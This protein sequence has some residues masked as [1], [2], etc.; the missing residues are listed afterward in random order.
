LPGSSGQSS[1]S[2]SGHQYWQSVA[3]IGIQVAEALAYAHA[4]G[5]LHRDIKPSNLLLDTRGTVWITDFGLAKEA[6]SGDLTH[7]GDLVGTLRYMAPERF[8]GKSDPRSDLYGLGL[9]LYELLTLRPAHDVADRNKLI[10]LVQHEEPPRPRKL[11]PEVPRDLETIVLKAIA[12]EPEHRYATAAALAE[13]L[14]R[15]VEDKPIQARRVG[16]V[17][18]LWRWCR[19]NR[20]IASLLAAVALLLIAVTAVA[21]TFAAY[22]SKAN[23]DLS[24][25]LD[26]AERN[27]REAE[28]RAAS[29]AVDLDLK[30]CEDRAVEY[31]VLRLAR[32]LGTLPPHAKELRL[33]VE[34]NLL[35]WSQD[36]Q[37]RGPTFEYDGAETCRELSP[38]GL[39][40]LTG[41]ADGTARLWDAFTAEVRAT[42]RG[43]RGNIAS[44]AFSQ[45]GRVAM[46][47]G[48]D[49]TVRLWDAINGKARAVTAKQP[50]PIQKALLSP[51]GR[52]LLTIC[53]EEHGQVREAATA[54]WDTDT[55]QRIS[56][57]AGHVGQVN[58]AAFSPA[59]QILFTGGA[60]ETARLWSANDGRALRTLQEH[61]G[62]VRG[63]AF[64]PDGHV[65][66]TLAYERPA[67]VVRWWNLHQHVQIGPPCKAAELDLPDS[68][69]RLIHGDIAV[70]ICPSMGGPT[71][72]VCI[73]GMTN[74]VSMAAPS[75]LDIRADDDFLFDSEGR[76]Y[77]RKSGKLQ[78]VP[79][80]RKYS[81][82]LA[83]FATGGRFI[84]LS[85]LI[86]LHTEKL[87]GDIL[88]ST[89]RYVP[90]R[91][92]FVAEHWPTLRYVPV[93]G[94][95]L[96]AQV[97][98]LFAEVVTCE[99]PDPEGTTQSLDES[100]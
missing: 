60:D 54:L 87:I 80:G 58:D 10:A 9:T 97:A 79:S 67:S 66:G 85:R 42:L 83:R 70:W 41:G 78:A 30:Y 75:I 84:A 7:T 61:M 100:T 28:L 40:V 36:L 49:R 91:Q 13:D 46:T 15:F 98:Q 29:V 56:D 59:G 2:E 38:D 82:G 22:Q 24:D 45:N 47:V 53:H 89:Y 39:T 27:H 72:A 18:R 14:K 95:P 44:I 8:G 23:R 94:T 25:A 99:E 74:G 20:A 68:S 69:F 32:T 26:E 86:D 6:D 93:P 57:L 1:L 65:V 5:T 81:D 77:G 92:T 33:C 37:P 31:G 62:Q 21:V 76:S 3:R 17:E 51:D 52:R 4:Q 16:Q 64:S 34:M 43:H 35:A 19:R 71:G 55:G 11:N 96:D 88:N 73:N 50:R 12:K 63:V 90:G 48:E